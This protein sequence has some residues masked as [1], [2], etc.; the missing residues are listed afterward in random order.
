[1]HIEIL[2]RHF[3]GPFLVD[4]TSAYGLKPVKTPFNA[5]VLPMCPNKV[6]P[7][8]PVYTQGRVHGGS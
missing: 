4:S 5:K 7:M 2:G 6:L 1:M 3:G 8:S